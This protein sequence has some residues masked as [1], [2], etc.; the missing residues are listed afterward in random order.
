MEEAGSLPL[1]ESERYR[2]GL[3]RREDWAALDT[4]APANSLS[5]RTLHQVHG[6]AAISLV[7]LSARLRSCCRP[8]FSLVGLAT[9]VP[10]AGVGC[11]IVSL[12]SQASLALT[13][14]PS[15]WRADSWDASN[16]WMGDGGKRP[17][18]SALRGEA[19]RM[20]DGRWRPRL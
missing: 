1:A 15:T 9:V 11:P 17:T 5:L 13:V 20:V 6:L 8:A 18:W 14:A 19:G 3:L 7:G 12:S 2:G 10:R 4:G 16:Q